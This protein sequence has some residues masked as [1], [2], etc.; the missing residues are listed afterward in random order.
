MDLTAFILQIRY[1]KFSIA[2]FQDLF[3]HLAHI[4]PD[5]IIRCSFDLL[6][7]KSCLEQQMI[8]QG[9]FDY[10]E[11]QFFFSLLSV[12]YQCVYHILEVGG[13]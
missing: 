6:I 3:L 2:S 10:Q 5:L 8:P 7:H 13:V 9:C 11:L 12:F 4:L 1:S